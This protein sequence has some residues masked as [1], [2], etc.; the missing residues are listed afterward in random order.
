MFH[1]GLENHKQTIFTHIFSLI[2]YQAFFLNSKEWIHGQQSQ[3]L[4]AC[5]S[6][7]QYIFVPHPLPPLFIPGRVQRGFAWSANELQAVS[8]HLFFFVL[9]PQLASKQLTTFII[10]YFFL[11]ATFISLWNISFSKA[12]FLHHF[13]W[14]E[15]TTT[16]PSNDTCSIARLLSAIFDQSI[17]T[18]TKDSLYSVILTKPST[19]EPWCFVNVWKS[20]FRGTFLTG[21]HVHVCCYV[22]YNVFWMLYSALLRC[23][24]CALRGWQGVAVPFLKCSECFLV[25]LWSFLFILT[26]ASEEMYLHNFRQHLAW[27]EA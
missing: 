25:V 18:V 19:T 10:V 3:F 15:V 4:G 22:A 24:E 6:V 26:Y 1:I 12:H 27:V 2:F 5:L 14:Q 23:S 21:C 8:T 16:I 9:G 7:D 17:N 20:A 11:G 13:W